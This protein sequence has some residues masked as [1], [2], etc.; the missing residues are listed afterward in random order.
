[1]EFKTQQRELHLYTDNY[2]QIE[3]SALNYKPTGELYP[4]TQIQTMKARISFYDIK[5]HPND[6]ELISVELSK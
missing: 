3:F 4:C 2:F 1:M 5:G 6:G